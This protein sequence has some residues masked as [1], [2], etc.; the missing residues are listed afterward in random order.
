MR[1]I[2]IRKGI[3]ICI[4]LLLT[5]VVIQPVTAIETKQSLIDNRIEEDCGC[6]EVNDD[7]LFRIRV[8][9]ERIKIITNLILLKFGYISNITES[10]Q[11]ILRIISSNKILDYEIICFIILSIYFYLDLIDMV[12]MNLIDKFEDIPL[13]TN[14]IL[15]IVAPIV[16]MQ[17]ILLKIGGTYDCF[18]WEPYYKFNIK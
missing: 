10:C 7:D 1:K 11:D 16:L 13:I 4:I 14:M 18:D 12:L 2:L 3:A 17:V 15:I 9:L 8:L 5:G 6:E